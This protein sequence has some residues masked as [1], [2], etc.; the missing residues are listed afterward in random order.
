[1]QTRWMLET[2]HFEVG[3]GT[4]KSKKACMVSDILGKR[5]PANTGIRIDTV[6]FGL[7]GED[8]VL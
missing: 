5:E 2:C 4:E 6:R 8:V 1:M 7:N 3:D